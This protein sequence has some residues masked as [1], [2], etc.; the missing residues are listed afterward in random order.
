[1]SIRD[2]FAGVQKTEV[3]ALVQDPGYGDLEKH[4]LGSMGVQVSDHPI[5]G[6]LEVD[7]ETVVVSIAPQIPVKQII[8]DISSPALIIWDAAS[9]LFEDPDGP[10]NQSWR[11]IGKS[12]YDQTGPSWCPRPLLL[13]LDPDTLRAIR[14]DYTS[15]RVEG[16]LEYEYKSYP[17]SG[18]WSPAVSS[19][20]QL[21]MFVRK[22]E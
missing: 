15:S 4:V 21:E 5:R 7:S 12:P 13:E 14:S 19:H 18:D 9:G 3:K 2:F 20:L 17:L 8:T 16:R 6:F 11:E 1:M 22:E 10:S